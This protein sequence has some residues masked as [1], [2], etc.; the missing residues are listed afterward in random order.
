[1]KIEKKIMWKKFYIK[2]CGK[3]GKI[4]E[5]KKINSKLFTW[6]AWQVPL[7]RP[8][9]CTVDGKKWNCI[10]GCKTF[11]KNA[12]LKKMPSF[13]V[14][15]SSSKID[16]AALFENRASATERFWNFWNNL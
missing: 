2:I 3:R 6:Y 5:N 16:F 15:P 12:P 9:S 4:D 11:K 8:S 7:L 14:V 13:K 1:M 10:S